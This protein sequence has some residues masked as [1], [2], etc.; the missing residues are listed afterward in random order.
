MQC[1]FVTGD[2]K[3]MP[4]EFAQ[5]SIQFAQSTVITMPY[6]NAASAIQ[7]TLSTQDHVFLFLKAVLKT[8]S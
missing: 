1:V 6:L 5:K 7:V 8:V 4:M 3:R 2:T